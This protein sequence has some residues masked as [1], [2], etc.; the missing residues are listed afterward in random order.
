MAKE[1]LIT[2][3]E[4][5]KVSKHHDSNPT[6]NPKRD[7]NPNLD[8]NYDYLSLLYRAKEWKGL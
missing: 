7:P 6:T 2:V 8:P 4:M 3:N 1:K 5:K